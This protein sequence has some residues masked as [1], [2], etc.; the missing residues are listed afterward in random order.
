MKSLQWLR[1]CVSRDT[2][3]DEYKSLQQ[4]SARSRIC[5]R[6]SAKET[7]QCDHT[8]SILSKIKQLRT[9]R[10][11]KPFVLAIALQFF[12]QFSAIMTWRPY[13]IQILNA[14]AIRWN[15]SYTAV[16]MSSMGLVAKIC[17]ISLIKLIGK[18]KLYLVASAV[19]YLSCFGLSTFYI[20]SF[21]MTWI[22]NEIFL[23]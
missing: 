17:S 23:Y 18:R 13:I 22:L 4:Y 12:L 9:K 2:V 21:G 7:M 14:Y 11:M 10:I 15:A 16:V 6:C 8:E 5:S 1:G 20:Y 3:F 19:T